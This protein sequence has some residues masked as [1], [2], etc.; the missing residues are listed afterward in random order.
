MFH[1]NEWVLPSHDEQ[2][3][4][5]DLM[6]YE[7]FMKEHP[8]LGLTKEQYY[9]ITDDALERYIE[10]CNAPLAKNTSRAPISRRAFMIG[11]LLAL[12]S[13]AIALHHNSSHTESSQEP[14]ATHRQHKSLEKDDNPRH[15]PI[16]RDRYG[17]PKTMLTL[18][19]QLER[20]DENLD[21][22]EAYKAEFQ[23]Y[24]QRYQKELPTLRQS[25]ERIT[26]ANVDKLLTP[27]AERGLA[28]PLAWMIP[29]KESGFR[30]VTARHGTKDA[31]GEYQIR[32]STAKLFQTKYHL[33]PVYAHP[34][35]NLY[36]DAELASIIMEENYKALGDI[37]LALYAYNAGAGLFGYTKNTPKS[38]RSQE[39]FLQYMENY[40]KQK[41]ATH[42]HD[43]PAE[44]L[45][46][47]KEALTYVPRM[48]AIQAVLKKHRLDK[49][50]LAKQTPKPYTTIA[51]QQ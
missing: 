20:G 35:K 17:N 46:K 41:I 48:Y 30:D 25:V 19:E 37:N 14:T 51:M 11:G 4:H 34:G 26:E 3:D 24:A 38:Q 28:T 15:V 32:P 1:T 12:A 45:G 8:G 36:R 9:S 44:I 49:A 43:D 23:E 50:I 47:V 18:D 29:L 40:I 31:T 22:T 33:P 2:P 13:A 21:L 7:D 27:F 16:E 39:G 10:Q 5:D 42:P 6:P